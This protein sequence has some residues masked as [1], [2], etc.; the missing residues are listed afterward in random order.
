[1]KTRTKS[2]SPV[3]A[4]R[5]RVDLPSVDSADNPFSEETQEN[6]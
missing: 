3:D 1:V 2:T 5:A 4:M 6:S